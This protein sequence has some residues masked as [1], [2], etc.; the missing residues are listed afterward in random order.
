MAFDVLES[1]PA[2]G[3]FEQINIQCSFRRVP[4]TSERFPMYVLQAEE[5]PM[6]VEPMA[7]ESA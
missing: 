5:L 6:P 2:R 3:G 4:P 7:A 1:Q